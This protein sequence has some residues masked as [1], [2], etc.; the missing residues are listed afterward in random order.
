MKYNSH[1][2]KLSVFLILCCIG[3]FIHKKLNIY[4]EN[5]N[6]EEPYTLDDNL[7]NVLCNSKEFKEIINLV[8][9][10]EGHSGDS[11][12]G[13]AIISLIQKQCLIVLNEIQK[14]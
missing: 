6:E 1:V 14:H 10:M 5:F 3:Y 12:D 2:I 11:Q 9:D 4:R 8:G 7:N 13:E